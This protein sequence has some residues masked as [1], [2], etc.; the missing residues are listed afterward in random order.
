M[1]KL[2]PEQKSA[3]KE[4]LRHPSALLFQGVMRRVLLKDADADIISSV[5]NYGELSY[6]LGLKKGIEQT[7]SG[8]DEIAKPDKT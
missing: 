4:W 1:Q 5:N 2:Q 6:N 3:L 7:L 8:M